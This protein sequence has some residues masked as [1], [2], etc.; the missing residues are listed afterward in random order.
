MCFP[1]SGY[2]HRWADNWK[3]CILNGERLSCPHAT[4]SRDE[5]CDVKLKLSG[6]IMESRVDTAGD[7]Q[8]AYVIISKYQSLVTLISVRF[9][10]S[11]ISYQ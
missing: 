4:L 3:S 1:P 6:L 7:N 11:E 10:I 9:D 2:Q 8:N 5:I